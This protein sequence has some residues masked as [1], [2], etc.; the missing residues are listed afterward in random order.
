MEKITTILYSVRKHFLVSWLKTMAWPCNSV[1]TSE[2]GF[3]K[4]RKGTA[5]SCR[6]L[7]AL[8]SAAPRVAQTDYFVRGDFCAIPS[9]CQEVLAL[10]INQPGVMHLTTLWKWRQWLGD[11]LCQSFS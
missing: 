1:L 11:L 3:R 2:H 5:S 9:A 10:E 7:N 8:S 4:A 6:T